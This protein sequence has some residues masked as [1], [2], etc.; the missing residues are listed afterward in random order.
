MQ[1]NGWAYVVFYALNE[2]FSKPH[3]KK[4]CVFL[5]SQVAPPYP[6]GL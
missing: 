4:D 2:A 1:E 5:F 3:H 6:F